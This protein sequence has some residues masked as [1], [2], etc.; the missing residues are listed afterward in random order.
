MINAF[1]F[2]QFFNYLNYSLIFFS[3]ARRILN[4]LTS[5]GHKDCHLVLNRKYIF[6]ALMENQVL[7]LKAKG[8]PSEFLSSQRTEKDRKKILADIQSPNP[9]TKLLYVTPELLSTKRY[10]LDKSLSRL[11]SMI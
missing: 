9:S 2:G 5:F 7:A 3:R 6:A 4:C 11:S 8:V 1:T 10:N